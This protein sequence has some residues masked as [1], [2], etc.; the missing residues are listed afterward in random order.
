MDEVVRH[1]S[2]VH[3][4][5]AAVTRVLFHV[6][7]VRVKTSIENHVVHERGV[8]C[9][10]DDGL[11]LEKSSQCSQWLVRWWSAVGQY[12]DDVHFVFEGRDHYFAPISGVR[13]VRDQ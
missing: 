10:R 3:A 7:G 5:G 2:H 4:I 9:R 1:V 6:S 12:P 8:R 13:L 11:D